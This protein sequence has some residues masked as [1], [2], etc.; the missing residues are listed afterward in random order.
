MNI[1][2]LEIIEQELDLDE[3]LAK[4]IDSLPITDHKK[5]K[6]RKNKEIVVKDLLFKHEFLNNKGEKQSF[7]IEKDWESSGTMRYYGLAG[8][9][10]SAVNKNKTLFIDELDTSLHPDLMK[11]FILTFLANSS[12]AQMMFTTHNISF[13]NER[14]IL[15][16]DVIWFT[17]KKRMDLLI[18]FQHQILVLKK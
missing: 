2:D 14:G 17:E 15:R 8:P 10:L 18:C 4:Q 3:D 6:I 1:S 5:E 12:N 7:K 16:N 13:L 9:M 11:H